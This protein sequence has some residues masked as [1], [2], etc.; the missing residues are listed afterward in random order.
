LTIFTWVGP[1]H[2]T[3]VPALDTEGEMTSVVWLRAKPMGVPSSPRAMLTAT[4][5]PR[6]W[7]RQPAMSAIC[8]AP[9]VAPGSATAGLVQSPKVT[10]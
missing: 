4:R 10:T 5:S 2:A 6:S 1:V 7:P 9:A 3:Q 8:R